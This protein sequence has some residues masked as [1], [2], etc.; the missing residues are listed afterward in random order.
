MAKDLYACKDCNVVLYLYESE[1]QVSKSGAMS[2]RCPVCGHE[3]FVI[4]IPS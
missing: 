3:C 4:Q 2:A 1:V